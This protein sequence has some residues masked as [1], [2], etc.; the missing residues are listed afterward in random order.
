KFAVDKNPDADADTDTKTDK[1]TQPEALPQPQFRHRHRTNVVLQM[2][3]NLE[4]SGQTLS[5][6]NVFPARDRFVVR[7]HAALRINHA[8]DADSDTKQRQ[9]AVADRRLDGFLD[10]LQDLIDRFALGQSS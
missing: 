4:L 10:F 2:N 1:V 3:R 7:C 5:D 6:W 9:P 8:G